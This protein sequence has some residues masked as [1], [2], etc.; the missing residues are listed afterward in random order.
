MRLSSWS[1]IFSDVRERL[2][3]SQGIKTVLSA[4]LGLNSQEKPN[5]D[6]TYMLCVFYGRQ[7]ITFKYGSQQKTMSYTRSNGQTMGHFTDVVK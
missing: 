1:L 7:R 3:G 6:L 4:S 2:R 5:L